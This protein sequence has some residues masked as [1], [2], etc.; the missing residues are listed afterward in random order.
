MSG[1]GVFDRRHRSTTTGLLVLVTFVAFE[2]MAVAT[3]MPTAVT[4]L[5]GLAWYGW[6][7][8]AFL[9]AQVVGMVV[10]GEVGD[11][12]GPRAAL[13]AGVAV[14]A[15][16][17]LAAG[18]AADMALFV[19]GRAVQGLGGGLISVSIYV[20]AGAA[21]EARLRPAL[22][23]ALS[24]AWVVP[25]LVGPL[26]AGVLTAA[27]TW[28]LVFLG[29]LPLVVVGLALVL[30]AL[31]SLTAPSAPGGGGPGRRWWA[32]LSG[33]GVGA[34]Q[35]A[36]QRLDLVAVPIAVVGLA[37]L[38]VGLGRLLPRGTGRAARGLPSV[39]ASRGLL[40][41]AFF[42]VESLIP[43]SLTTLHGYPATTAGVPLT[44]AALGWSLASALQGRRPDL[45]RVRLLQAGFVLVTVGVAGTALVA[46][47]GLHGWAT[48]VTWA[49][50]GTGMGLGMSSVGVLLLEQS[51]E[52]RRGADS[53]SL[54]IADVT[55]SAVCIGAV[56]V[57][58]AAA[59]AGSLPLTAAVLAAVGGLTGVAVL[60]ALVAGRCRAV[61]DGAGARAGATTLAAS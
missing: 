54:Q 42:G 60:G 17:L 55:G 31:R 14:F 37:A 57:L 28:R 2:A 26:V 25:A 45:S 12:R 18:L 39:V 51:P 19:L 49:V 36:G 8:T 46:V 32:V 52:H 23:G 59:T 38:L 7:F 6:P 1:P 5:D 4:E 56:G 48:Y 9:V 61:D 24:A 43:F 3:A 47:P 41:G 30:P 40:A 33:V 35:Y 34:L 15:A 20:V 21:Y 10:G 53:A 13:L 58:L 50:A 11:R 44:A 29:I 22:F 27:A 16:G